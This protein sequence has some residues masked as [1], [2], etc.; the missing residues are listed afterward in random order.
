MKKQTSRS[1]LLSIVVL[2][3]LGCAAYSAAAQAVYYAPSSLEMREFIAK[4]LAS[5]DDLALA[6]NEHAQN[7][8]QFFQQSNGARFL[9]YY[10]HHAE[11]EMRARIRLIPHNDSDIAESSDIR[12]GS[13][14]IM[15]DKDYELQKIVYYFQN[16]GAYNIAF[17]AL[18]GISSIAVH[19][20][21]IVNFAH[22]S[23]PIALQSLLRMKFDDIL[24]ATNKHVAWQNMLPMKK[25]FKAYERARQLA[26]YLGLTDEE[27]QPVLPVHAGEH[28]EEVL[29]IARVQQHFFEGLTRILSYIGQNVVEDAQFL[30]TYSNGMRLG[31]KE[32]TYIR[33]YADNAFT[34]LETFSEFN[35]QQL[36]QKPTRIKATYT[37]LT[38]L[39]L[40]ALTNPARFYIIISGINAQAAEKSKQ[41]IAYD[42]VQ[43]VVPYFTPSGEFDFYAQNRHAELFG[44]IEDI[45]QQSNTENFAQSTAYRRVV[46]LHVLRVPNNRSYN[47]Q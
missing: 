4:Q 35:A 41:T 1:A 7:S 23:V 6:I 34:F 43:I 22:V 31:L 27:E 12:Y 37:M 46:F 2:L 26:M 36:P 29:T 47:K 32:P 11:E 3:M 17:S 40:Y 30:P 25:N 42:S 21:G 19:M 39:Y 13:W 28:N 9:V 38:R 15:L 14:D 33:R 20:G 44:N 5:T 8:P 10:T 18:R 45:S 24:Q 16:G